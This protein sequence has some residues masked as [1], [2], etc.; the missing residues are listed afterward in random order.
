[1]IGVMLSI[2]IVPLAAG[3]T[4]AVLPARRTRA[5][6]AVTVVAGVA[7]FALVLVLVPA[8]ANHDLNYLSYLRVDAVSA[9]LG[10]SAPGLRAARWSCPRTSQ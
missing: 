8:A 7:C 4:C 2:L 1:V 10:C 6:A 5:A 3:I 9:I